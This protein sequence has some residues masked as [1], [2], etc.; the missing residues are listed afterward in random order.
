[1]EQDLRA[2]LADELSDAAEPPIGDLV[3]AALRRGRRLRTLRRLGSG[4]AAVAV[5]GALAA[6][7]ALLR[8]GPVPVAGP[9]SG[10]SPPPVASADGRV[11]ATPAGLLQ[12]LLGLLPPGATSG[13][14]ADPAQP[15]V[16]V[17]LDAGAGPGMLRVS[18]ARVA[19]HEPM[20]IG[21]SEPGFEVH[22]PT[23]LPGGYRVLVLQIEDN[24]VQRTVVEVRHPD[25][26]QVQVDIASC[27]AWDGEQNR[28]AP[29]ALSVAQATAVASDP[30]W[31]LRIDPAVE[32]AGAGRFPRLAAIG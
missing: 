18:V 32:A 5:I 28:P 16:Q 8:P 6:A 11:R 9:A 30:R 10:G 19:P 4:G 13:Y 23:D 14:A 2:R 17:Y 12:L 29:Q 3:G 7:G 15:M 25:G 22:G 24:C 31:G 27:L 20:F 1:M 21:Q 26:T